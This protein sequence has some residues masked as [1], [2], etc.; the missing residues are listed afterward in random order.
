MKRKVWYYIL[1]GLFGAVFLV[2]AVMLITY[3]SRSQKQAAVYE[4]LA[5]LHNMETAPEIPVDENG[6]SQPERIWVTVKSEETETEQKMLPEFEELYRRNPD[7][8]GWI[9]IPGTNIDYPVMHTPDRTDHY[10]KKNF[11]GE[12]SAQGSIYAREQCDLLRPSDN[13]TLY[14]HHMKDGSMFAALEDYKS[15]DFWQEHRYISLSSLQQRHTY[16]IF[17]V[18][19]TTASVG[20]GFEYH[21]FVDAAD[22][23]EYNEF[24]QACKALSLYDTGITPVY[25]DKLI[26]LSTCE[27]SQTNGRLVVVARC[28]E[29]YG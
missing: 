4:E 13:V 2:S 15:R 9:T 22:E 14:G 6:V 19:T 23:A 5:Q 20:E 24:V 25:G 8:A 27:Y 3:Y 10:L 16:E 18:F 17:A 12:Y 26:T 21:T 11:Y 1:L 29:S 7:I 28:M